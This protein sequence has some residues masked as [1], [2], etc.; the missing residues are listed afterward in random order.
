MKRIFL[1]MLVLSTTAA[2][3]EQVRISWKGDYAHNS[4]KH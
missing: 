2:S 4:G 1:L 3:A